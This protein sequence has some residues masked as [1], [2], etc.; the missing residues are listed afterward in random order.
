MKTGTELAIAPL[1][2]KLK[3]MPR[4]SGELVVKINKILYANAKRYISPQMAKRLF[5]ELVELGK[6]LKDTSVPP[7]VRPTKES[8][9]RKLHETCMALRTYSKE[10]LWVQE[11]TDAVAKTM[12]YELSMY[13][14]NKDNGDFD[15]VTTLRRNKEVWNEMY[16]PCPFH[17]GI[18]TKKFQQ[19]QDELLNSLAGSFQ[20]TL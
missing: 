6:A 11:D 16:I 12:R 14:K 8:V 18:N 5:Q 1:T 13:L 3:G 9:L 19:M 15:I 10:Y 2:I 17:D 20:L 4:P 7:I